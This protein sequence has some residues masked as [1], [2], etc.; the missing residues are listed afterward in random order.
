[1]YQRFIDRLVHWMDSC[2]PLLSLLATPRAVSRSLSSSTAK[3]YE[4]DPLGLF[5]G[6]HLAGQKQVLGL[7]HTAQQMARPMPHD[8]RRRCPSRVWP[9]TIF[10]FLAAIEMSAI[11]ATTRPGADRGPVD[12]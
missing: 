1:M 5:A 2:A 6:N 7:G 12:R 4:A 10:A 11:S 9:S 3:R 8:R